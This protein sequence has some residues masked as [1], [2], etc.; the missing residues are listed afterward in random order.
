M[1]RLIE[2]LTGYI[3]IRSGNI[4]IVINSTA[5]INILTGPTDIRNGNMFL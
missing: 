1:I 2:I 5:N 3:E 4:A